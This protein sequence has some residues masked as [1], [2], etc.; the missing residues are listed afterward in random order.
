MRGVK[1]TRLGLWK[2]CTSCEAVLPL[3][4][5]H[6]NKASPDGR[7]SMCKTCKNAKAR[8]KYK[9][10]VEKPRKKYLSYRERHLQTHYGI[11]VSQFDSLLKKQNYCCAVCGKHSDDE[12][13][14]LHVDHDHKT[15][16]IRGL[17]CNFCN[18]QIIGRHRNPDIFEAAAKYLRGGTGW[19]VPK[20][21]PKRRRRKK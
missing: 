12:K 18:R 10:K 6:Q 20:K 8:K 14:S 4:E 3:D 11:S 5:F 7:H 2:T 13:K 16:E 1:P 21:R 17:L 19:F 15:G 9:D